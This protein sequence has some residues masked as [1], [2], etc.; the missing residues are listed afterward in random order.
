MSKEEHSKL[1]HPDYWGRDPNTW[2]T[3]ND[4]DIYWI[5]QSHS[6]PVNKQNSH[7]VLADELRTIKQIFDSTK[8]AYKIVCEL[9]NELKESTIFFGFADL[10]VL[11][12]SIANPATEFWEEKDQITSLKIESDLI[13]LELEID[14]KRGR[15]SVHKITQQGF[16]ITQQGLQ[17]CADTEFDAMERGKK[18][19]RTGQE[20]SPLRAVTPPPFKLSQV[21][22]RTSEDK[23]RSTASET[24]VKSTYSDLT[25]SDESLSSSIPL[26]NDFSETTS[27]ESPVSNQELEDTETIPLIII[28]ED[29]DVITDKKMM[30]DAYLKIRQDLCD[31][32]SQ[33]DWFI[34]GYN[35][36]DAFRKYQISNIDKLVAGETFHFSSDNE[37]ILSLHNI[38]FIDLTTMKKPLYLDIDDERKWR[39]SIRQQK[40]QTPPSFFGEIVDEYEMEINDIDELRSKFY[41]MW[42]KYRD[43]VIYSDSERRLFETTQAVARAFFERMHI[44]FEQTPKVYLQ[45][46]TEKLMN[47]PKV[48]SLTLQYI[49]L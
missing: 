34:E 32:F 25:F 39:V 42:G 6:V 47:V 35:V 10:V 30:R 18:R 26:T 4:W 9:Q 12:Y 43:K 45:E 11:A 27:Q 7:S 49:E 17:E 41:D 28:N 33:K 20:V 14:R 16:K 23:D 21:Q 48:E 29:G 38:M 5:E 31:H 13:D 40:Q 37:E 24:E 3:V 44:L 22:P 19:I 46:N 36:S 8:P 1:R 2:G 15:Q